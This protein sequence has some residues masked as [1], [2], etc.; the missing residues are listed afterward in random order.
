[1]EE[2]IDVATLENPTFLHTAADAPLLYCEKLFGKYFLEYRI[3]E[4]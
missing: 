1:M 3:D 2:A 4:Q